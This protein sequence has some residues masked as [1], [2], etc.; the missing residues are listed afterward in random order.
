MKDRVSPA[1]GKVN[2]EAKS[3]SVGGLFPLP[4]QEHHF[5]NTMHIMEEK[6]EIELS[7]DALKT[8]PVWFPLHLDLQYLKLYR[9]LEGKK[10]L[11]LKST[12]L[13]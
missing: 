7:W 5:F 11:C 3:G 13:N 10:M 8:V 4:L 1:E 9:P 6:L 12:L 2:D